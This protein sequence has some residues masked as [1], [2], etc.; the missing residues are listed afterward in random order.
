M[1]AVAGS[2]V[3]EIKGDLGPLGG[4]FTQTERAARALDTTVQRAG[5]SVSRTA[6]AAKHGAAA[7]AQY[8]TQA[9]A[10][11]HSTRAMA[12]GMIMG[13]PPTQMLAMQMS[14]LTYAASGPG[15]LGAAFRETGHMAKELGKTLIGPL[16]TPL[17]L[18]LTTIVALGAAFYFTNKSWRES[19]LA[20][21]DLSRA[22][23]ETVRNLRSLESVAAAH[24]VSN[25]AEAA[26]KFSSEIYKANNNMG[27]LAELMRANGERASTFADYLTNVADLVRRASSDQQRL[28][29][30][31]QAGLPATM[32]W[33]RFLQ[34]G[35]DAIRQAT[36]E[37][38]TFGDSAEQRM[39]EAARRS[40]EAWAK[41]FSDF[42]TYAQSALV[43]LKSWAYS[44]GAAISQ[45]TENFALRMAQGT[46]AYF[47][48]RVGAGFRGLESGYNP[49]LQQA[50]ENRARQLRGERTTV[51]PA[52]ERQQ[53]SMEL[54]R[55]QALGQLATVEQQVHATEL[56]LRLERMQ[57]GSRI[58]S[59]DT[60]RVVDFT[61]AQAESARISDQ[62]SVGIFHLSEARRAA[63]NQLK[64]WIDLGLVDKNNAMEMAAAHQVLADRIR[65]TAEQAA[66]AS[67]PFKELKQLELD[68]G[69][70]TKLLDA[71]ATSSLNDLTS[72]LADMTSGT[73]LAGDAFSNLGQKVVRAVEEMI[74]KMTVIM[75]IAKALQAVL[76][77]SGGGGGGIL[78]LLG[79]GGV[80]SAGAS[81]SLAAANS[82]ATG[83]SAAELAFAFHAGGVV[84][85]GGTPARVPAS[86]FVNAPRFAAG[87]GARTP[88]INEVPV[89]AHRG[90]VIGWPSQMR[91]AF[92]G[93]SA[94]NIKVNVVNAPAGVD[95]VRSSRGSDGSL[96]LDV[97]LR[98]MDQRNVAAFKDRGHPMTR[99]LAQT[100][101]VNMAAGTAS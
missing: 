31:Q 91:Q 89:L 61:R 81:G 9:M 5:Q 93:G 42:G 95:D 14:H 11:F 56:R 4:A 18:A 45:V 37:A 24:G 36:R 12:E 50:L 26:T 47:N 15:G 21:D 74:I 43:H 72:S 48:A 22:S 84:G 80:S 28:T 69:N 64:S 90:E 98:K 16:L 41:M 27:S 46:T 60:R 33:V 82:A 30:L 32:N 52:V 44:V 86:V 25:F 38:A 83:V 99:A 65:Q 34:Q 70:S 51:D 76:G 2:V 54:Q 97:I 55:I 87:L 85:A 75:P 29:V 19:V 62:A 71:V 39:V 88:G 57:P 73:K 3:V 63:S 92:G 1:A 17:G 78:S 59:A 67:T 40:D 94:V 68:A 79:L 23:G 101:G 66:L 6:D 35:S 8:S 77:A 53:I 10:A 49:A 7:H 100:F 13:I 20:L 58:T 96:T